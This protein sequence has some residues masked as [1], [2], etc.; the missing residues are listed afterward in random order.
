MS[1]FIADRLINGIPVLQLSNVEWNPLWGGVF[2]LF[3]KKEDKSC[4]MV[5]AF[6]C[7]ENKV[8]R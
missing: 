5:R 7:H 1:F 2:I 6:V 8:G 3:F 4:G